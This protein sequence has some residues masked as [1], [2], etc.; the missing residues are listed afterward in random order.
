M[1]VALAGAISERSTGTDELG[2]V[3]A[4]SVSVM[5]KFVIAAAPSY[6]GVIQVILAHVQVLLECSGSTGGEGMPKR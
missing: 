1:P 2:R 6:S 4:G 5:V 3:C